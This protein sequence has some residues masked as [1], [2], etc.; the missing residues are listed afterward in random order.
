MTGA[1]NLS[2]PCE[3]LRKLEHELRAVQA[4]QNDSYAAINAIR[5]AYHLREWIWHN[6][7]QRNPTLQTSIM[8]VQG[9][10]DVW[11]TWVNSQFPDFPVLRELCNGSKH[12]RLW[13]EENITASHQAGWDKQPWDKIPFDADGFH[14]ELDDGRTL[15]VTDLLTRAHSFWENLFKQHSL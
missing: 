2:N 3:L 1:L 4:N 10:Q 13:D 12:F 8:G 15:S 14:I 7:L 5:D 11:N 6:L 9:A